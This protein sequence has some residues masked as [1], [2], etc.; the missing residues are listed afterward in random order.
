M[1]RYLITYD[2]RS[3]D[4]DGPARLRRVAKIC[5]S[6]G[7]RVQKSVFECVLTDTQHHTFVSRL[8]DVIDPA[9]DSL[10]IYR[11]SE[12]LD[13]HLSVYGVDLS[14]DFTAPLIF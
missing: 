11:I 5:E 7:R 10:R 8:L 14:F 2:V 12:P 3:S 4:E 1:A 9:A 13:E 6:R